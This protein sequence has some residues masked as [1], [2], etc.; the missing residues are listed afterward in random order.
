[1][2]TLTKRP[3]YAFPN[4][5]R[6]QLNAFSLYSLEPNVSLSFA[7]GVTCLA[8]ANGIGKSTFLAT[9]N[10]GLTGAVPNPRRRLLSTGQY[11]RDAQE[12]TADFFDGRISE[13]DRDVA[14]ITLDFK[15][16]K[17]EYSIQRALFSP[18]EL[19][20]LSIKDS[21][22][23]REL[24]TSLTPVQ[25]DA[26]YRTHLCDDIGM[27]SFEQFVFFQHFLLTFDEARHLLFWDEAASTQMLYLCFGGDPSEAA[28]A[29]ELNRKMEQAGSWGRNLQ[30]QASNIGKR[31]SILEAS[32][33][34]TDAP[35]GIEQATSIY[36]ERLSALESAS[37][38]VN[39]A[40]QRVAE[41]ELRVAQAN[42]S[43]S[44]LRI[45]YS[46]A[47][48][49]LLHNASSP[50]N[51]PIVQDALQAS[52]CPVCHTASRDV[53]TKVSGKL[54]KHLCPLCEFPIEE[55]RAISEA[56]RAALAEIDGRLSVAR[57]TLNEASAARNRFAEDLKSKQQ[58]LLETRTHINE[59]E[60]SNNDL[61]EAI[62]VRVAAASGPLQ[63]NLSALQ[64]AREQLI[65]QRDEAYAE[66]DSFKEQLRLL[67]V[68][69]QGRYAKAEKEFV[70]TFR[71]LAEMFLGID[72]DVRLTSS[73][74]TAMKLQ[75]EMRG[76]SRQ[77]Q[78]QLSESQRFFVDIAL[79]MAIAE[80]ASA[81]SSKAPM[82][83]DT[84]EGSLDISYE[85][86]AGMMF[87]EFS[88]GGHSLL[89]TANINTSKLLTSMASIC[90]EKMM[91]LVPMTGWSELSDVQ[92]KATHLFKGAYEEISKA[93]AA[94]GQVAES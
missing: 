72:L 22:R 47:F 33:G 38:S 6:V 43:V 93:L 87:A 81:P 30:F 75:I 36:Q 28:K 20:S 8:G 70:P 78:H 59:F 66:R 4:I 82:F 84:P 41:S 64:Q 31:I 68:A 40:E 71:R 49:N 37:A 27:Q 16:G 24:G 85:D 3:R 15:I 29:D 58:V 79:R 63:Q 74:G 13:E 65:I 53:A 48:N 92:Q 42:A 51:H 10:F 90:G 23:P 89:M 67:Q 76:T 61:L 11:L 60:Q 1:M 2:P 77:Q 69:L 91:R 57:E 19:L 32:S 73:Q 62:K 39:E 56:A 14:A 46:D 7:K 83:I 55:T 88:L 34:S 5:A 9:V 80:Y 35:D 25:R 17:V 21:G 86:R 12:Y 50:K 45:T 54:A 94:G 18:T 26:L 44:A 52:A